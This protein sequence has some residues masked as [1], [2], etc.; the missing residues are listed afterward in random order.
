[1]CVWGGGLEKDAVRPLRPP[2]SEEGAMA[3]RR[4]VRERKNQKQISAREET[5]EDWQ[6]FRKGNKD[7]RKSQHL[8]RCHTGAAFSCVAPVQHSR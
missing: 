3:Y 5:L 8:P 6:R 2:E 7:V 4:V 1:M